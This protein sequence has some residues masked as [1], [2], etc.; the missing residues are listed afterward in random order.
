MCNN[1]GHCRKFDAGVMCPS[2]R[3]TRDEQHTTRG[4][5][6]TLRLAL[7]GQLGDEDLGGEAV[8]AALD[9][10]VSCKGC[11]R[12]CPTGVDMAKMKIESLAAY[13]QRHGIALRDRL[14]AHLPRYAPALSARRVACRTWLTRLPG[15]ARLGRIR[16]RAVGAA[17]RCRRGAA[18]SCSAGALGH[19]V[20]RRTDAKSC[21]SSTRSAIISRTKAP[22]TRARV[23]EA[24]GYT[25]HTNAV[26]GERPLCCGRTFLAAGWSTRRRPRHGERSTALVPYARRG[27]AIVGLEPSCLLGM[28]DEFLSYGFGEDAELV[29][30]HAMLFE[31]FL[32]RE[33][34]GRPPDAAVEAAAASARRCCTGIAIRKPSPR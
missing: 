1:N 21:C 31:E 17:S 30:R 23:L 34:S 29:A 24:A 5:A 12:E 10:C 28:R 22:P 9:L 26:P 32:V 15:A 2:Y 3:V 18:V 14:I 20:R 6:N 27:V 4:R 19:G 25:V 13:N 7:S 8:H 16:A 33:R 11:R